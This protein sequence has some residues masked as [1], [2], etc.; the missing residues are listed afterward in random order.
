M[1]RGKHIEVS[2]NK[3]P[4]ESFIK[5]KT[6]KVVGLFLAGAV[7]ISGYFWLEEQEDKSDWQNAQSSGGGGGGYTSYSGG[8]A[9]KGSS[10]E[11]ISSGSAAKGGIGSSAVGG[12]E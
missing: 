7:A 11:G 9:A 8:S 5:S 4:A 6:G 12:G 10:G 2:K 3:P 1:Y